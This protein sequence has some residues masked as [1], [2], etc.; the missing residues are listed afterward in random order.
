MNSYQLETL[1]GVVLDGDFHA[2]RLRIFTLR[3]GTILAAGQKKFED[4]VAAEQEN[5]EKEEEVVKLCIRKPR[6][7]LI[8]T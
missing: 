1:N 7:A 5:V 3:E 4:S 6:F 8:C 2:W